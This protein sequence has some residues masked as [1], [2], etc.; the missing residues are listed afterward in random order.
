MIDAPP[1]AS[2]VMATRRS[3]HFVPGGN[4]RML[5]KALATTPTAWC[6][7]WRTR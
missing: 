2:D 5:V 6:W 3:L 1:P 7:I 4:E